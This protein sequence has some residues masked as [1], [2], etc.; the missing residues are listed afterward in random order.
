MVYYG[1]FGALTKLLFPQGWTRYISTNTD[2]IPINKISPY[3]I[4]AKILQ[5]YCHVLRLQYTQTTYTDE[6]PHNPKTISNHLCH[7]T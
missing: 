4:T 5:N 7:I 2:Q 3:V 6:S 1:I